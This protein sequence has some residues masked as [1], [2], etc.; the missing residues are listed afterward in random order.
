MTITGTDSL[1]R[2]DKSKRDK[3]KMAQIDIYDQEYSILRQKS[4]DEIYDEIRNVDKL[5]DLKGLTQLLG[6]HI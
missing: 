3:D 1:R 5:A 6:A 2:C 4:L